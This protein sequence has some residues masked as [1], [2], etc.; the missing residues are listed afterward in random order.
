MDRDT[1]QPLHDP[2]TNKKMGRRVT[3]GEYHFRIK[4]DYNKRKVEK[5]LCALK[6][7]FYRNL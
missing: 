4:T 5:R 7:F 6:D 3:N 1:G 2:A